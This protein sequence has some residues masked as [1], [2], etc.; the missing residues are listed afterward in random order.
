M[1]VSVQRVAGATDSSHSGS[2]F[3]R[4]FGLDGNTFLVEENTTQ[5]IHV[6]SILLR[7]FIAAP[8][9]CH[10]VLDAG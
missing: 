7:R 2:H 6:A 3:G 8:V 10:Y 1:C 9:D 4:K 5:S